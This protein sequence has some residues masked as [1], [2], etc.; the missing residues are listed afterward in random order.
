MFIVIISGITVINVAEKV[1]VNYFTENFEDEKGQPLATST[2][3]GYNGWYL[4][5]DNPQNKDSLA[6]GKTRHEAA[7]D[8]GT[9]MTTRNSSKLY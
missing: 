7:R 4:E 8:E 1:S 5:S 9:T 3:E 6:A 2:T